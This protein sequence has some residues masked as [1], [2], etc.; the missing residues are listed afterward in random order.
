MVEVA[1]ELAGL[2]TAEVRASRGDAGAEAGLVFDSGRVNRLAV[3][4]AAT[5]ATTLAAHAAW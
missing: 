4:P 2:L 1:V 3:Q 5:A